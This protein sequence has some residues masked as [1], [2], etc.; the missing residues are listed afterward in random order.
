VLTSLNI[1]IDDD[2]GFS[3]LDEALSVADEFA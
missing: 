3:I 2:E 1:I